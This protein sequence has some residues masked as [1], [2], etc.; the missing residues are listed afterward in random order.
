MGVTE[1]ERAC[2][3]EDAHGTGRYGDMSPMIGL[4]LWEPRALTVRGKLG[5]YGSSMYCEME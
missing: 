1:T 3:T 5:R 2:R 4:S